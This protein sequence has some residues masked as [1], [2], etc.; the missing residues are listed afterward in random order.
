MTICI[1]QYKNDDHQKYSNPSEVIIVLLVSKPLGTWIYTE[2]LWRIN[3]HM[4]G[5]A[6]QSD[7]NSY[8]LAGPLNT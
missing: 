6:T 1:V 5:I 8:Y 7:K 2:L 4:H 3:H